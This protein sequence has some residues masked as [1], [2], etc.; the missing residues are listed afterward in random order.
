MFRDSPVPSSAEGAKRLL[1]PLSTGAKLCTPPEV[2]MQHLGFSVDLLCAR[3]K[4]HN[5]GIKN[6]L[7]LK[8]GAFRELRP[9]RCAEHA[10]RSRRQPQR[11]A[12][13]PPCPP[14]LC[15]LTCLLGQLRGIPLASGLCSLLRAW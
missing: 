14:V 2:D 13:M 1:H 5:N 3:V 4:P 7:G 12:G 15:L 9:G 10:A 8:Q 6:K 11:T